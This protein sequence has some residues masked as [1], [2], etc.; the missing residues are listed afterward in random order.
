MRPEG[1]VGLH[2]G[3]DDS[4][5]GG[6]GNGGVDG[7][8]EVGGSSGDNTGDDVGGED[9][10]MMEGLVVGD[11]MDDRGNSTCKGPVVSGNSVCLK[12]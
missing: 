12:T 11:S 1:E 9:V 6:S 5:S 10:V 7:D 8:G 3:M 4:A 2:L